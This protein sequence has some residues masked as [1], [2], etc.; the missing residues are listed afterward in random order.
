MNGTSIAGSGVITT[1]DTNWAL[2]APR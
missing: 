1:V 2:V